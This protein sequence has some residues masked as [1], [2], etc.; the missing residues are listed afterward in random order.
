MAIEDVQAFLATLPHDAVRVRVRTVNGLISYR[1]LDE[2]VPTDDPVCNADGM[3]VVMR[4]RIGAPSKFLRNQ[5]NPVP[6]ALQGAIASVAAGTQTQSSP[7]IT[8][9]SPDDGGV[10]DPEVQT[11][12]TARQ[13]RRRRYGTNAVLREVKRNPSSDSVF[14]VLMHGLAEEAE[15]LEFERDQLMQ[16]KQPTLHL[17]EQRVKVM[18]MMTDA[19]IKRRAKSGGAGVDLES[20]AFAAVF[21]FVLE[22]V[23]SAMEDA[24]ARQEF[25][26]TIFAKL[27]KRLNDDWKNEALIRIKEKAT[28]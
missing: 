15:L 13:R 22:T 16:L 23:R 7:T 3:P 8:T 12:E 27:S 9:A 5:P 21:G 2:I 24:G 14:D 6:M 19:W 26:E 1:K 11:V 25:I 28:S 18:K 10:Q 17:T 20:P 4:G